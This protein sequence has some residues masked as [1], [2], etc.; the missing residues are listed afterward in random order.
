MENSDIDFNTL[1]SS[2]KDWGLELGFDAVGITDTK[3]EEAEHYLNQWISN[4][5]HGEMTW[6]STATR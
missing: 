2:I 4:G 1:S 6:I 3:L 5:Y